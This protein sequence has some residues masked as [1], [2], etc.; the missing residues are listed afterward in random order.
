MNNNQYSYQPQLPPNNNQY[1]YQPQPPP[2]LP[3]NN[4][5]TY[6]AFIDFFGNIVMKL[7]NTNNGW[8]VYA[9]SVN[10]LQNG[11]KYIYAVVYSGNSFIQLPETPLLESITGGSPVPNC[12]Q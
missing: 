10:H 12:N 1:S 11:F 6:G 9:T 5:S 7:I 2:Q 3:P 8:S 4:N